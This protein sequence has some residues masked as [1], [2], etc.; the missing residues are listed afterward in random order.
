MRTDDSVDAPDA[1]APVARC[2]FPITRIGVSI[3]F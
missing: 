2:R 3:V 1:G